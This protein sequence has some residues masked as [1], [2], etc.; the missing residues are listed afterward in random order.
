[1]Y[2]WCFT[3]VTTITE[4]LQNA[5]W[6]VEKA[7]VFLYQIDIYIYLIETDE[8]K[9]MS[10]LLKRYKTGKKYLIKPY[11]WLKK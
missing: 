10:W 6:N 11:F 9:K 4:L 1:M 5:K 2:S 7:N 8:C 3:H